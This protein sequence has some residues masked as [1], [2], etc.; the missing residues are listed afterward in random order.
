MDRS[1][2]VERAQYTVYTR[3]YTIL[4]S[5][6]T[7]G[8]DIFDELHWVSIDINVRSVSCLLTQRKNWNGIRLNEYMIEYVAAPVAAMNARSSQFV[9]KHTL[10]RNGNNV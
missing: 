7:D 9:V 3:I 4:E 10:Q 2:S 6:Y 8:M 1:E 5:H